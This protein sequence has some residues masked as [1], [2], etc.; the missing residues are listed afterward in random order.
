MPGVFRRT[1][2]ASPTQRVPI[3]VF[4][5]PVNADLSVTE[6]DD[7]LSASATLEVRASL[8]ATE[9]NDALSSSGTLAIAATAAITEAG[10]TLTSA[11]KLDILATA[12]I[13]EAGDTLSA[14]G[15]LL[16]QGALSSTE[17]GDTLASTGALPISAT[18][19]AT[20]QGDTL[21]ADSQMPIFYPRRGGIDEREEFERRQREWQENLRRIIDR[22]FRIANGE[23]DPIT[24]EPIP[25]PDYSLVQD[26]LA[27][28]AIALDRQRI[29]QFKAE[30]SRLQEDEAMA[31]LLLAA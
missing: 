9:A 3:G 6:Q 7:T 19:S 20:E 16:V 30:Q 31:I 15:A 13:T 24:F 26:L 29:E 23:I 2:R 17:A 14:T 4:V 11:A 22:S 28:Q 21:S 1:W 8:A 27:S 5:S 10:D 12:A 18:L 25:P